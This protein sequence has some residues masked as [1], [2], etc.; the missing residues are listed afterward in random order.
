VNTA[1]TSVWRNIGVLLLLSLTVLLLLYWSTAVSLVEQW[2]TSLYSYAFLT[3]PI[4][5]FL[6]WRNR[7]RLAKFTPA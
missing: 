1:A 3:V 4:A 5:G 2:N 7:E 6:A